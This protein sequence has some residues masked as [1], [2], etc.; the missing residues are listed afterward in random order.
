VHEISAAGAPVIEKLAAFAGIFEQRVDALVLGPTALGGVR[1]AFSSLVARMR[2][3]DLDFLVRELE[4][5]FGAVKGKLQAVGP[6]AVKASVQS[7]FDHALASLDVANL[8][9]AGELAALDQSYEAILTGLRALDP[10]KLVVEAVQPEFDKKVMPLLAA[11]DITVVLRALIER[12]DAL[13]TE[14]SVEFGKVDDAYKAMLAAVPTLSLTDISLD[15]D[16]DVGVDLG[17]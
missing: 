6:S 3:I 17:F 14:L 16:I 12:L 5:T 15:V 13:K 2:A 7:A 10:K 1:D 9:P 8:L 11:F 4:T